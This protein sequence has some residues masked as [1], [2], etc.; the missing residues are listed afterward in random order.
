MGD[1]VNT[2]VTAALGTK[3]RFISAGMGIKATVIPQR[4]G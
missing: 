4:W 3:L 1:C 2:A